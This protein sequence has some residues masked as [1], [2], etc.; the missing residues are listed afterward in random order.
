MR[1]V[2]HF[3]LEI[4]TE[5]FGEVFIATMKLRRL[6]CHGWSAML[7]AR[8]GIRGEAQKDGEPCVGPSLPPLCP[9]M[10]HFFHVLLHKALSFQESHVRKKNLTLTKRKTLILILP[11]LK[12]IESL[13][14]GSPIIW[15]PGCLGV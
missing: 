9:A 8:G 1:S 6:F 12:K 7:L 3:W 10:S 15:A 13:C 4:E 14:L 2:A 5:F 11:T